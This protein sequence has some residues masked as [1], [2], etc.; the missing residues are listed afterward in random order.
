M[1][2][3][4]KLAMLMLWFSAIAFAEEGDNLAEVFERKIVPLE[5]L[6]PFGIE[7]SK[8]FIPAVKP[9]IG[10]VAT[11]KGG[12]YVLHKNKKNIYILFKGAPLFENDKIIT[13]ENSELIAQMLDG[14]KLLIVENTKMTLNSAATDH[15]EYIHLFFG[16][17]RVLA[18]KIFGGD[19]H[20]YKTATATVGIRGSD[21]MLAVFSDRQTLS[22][23]II[24]GQDT[25]VDF[26][27]AVGPA[28]R[29]QSFQASFAAAGQQAHEP[30]KISRTKSPS[31]LFPFEDRQDSSLT[32]MSEDQ[33]SDVTLS[34][35]KTENDNNFLPKSNPDNNLTMLFDKE[36]ADKLEETNSLQGRL[37]FLNAEQLNL[38][39]EINWDF[40][41]NIPLAVL[42]V[43]TDDSVT[44]NNLEVTSNVTRIKFNPLQNV[45][46]GFNYGNFASQY[47]TITP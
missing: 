43:A 45:Y 27:G 32:E 44:F 29:L 1:K 8:K 5:S 33:L 3:F 36:K 14:N 18:A 35:S 22:T 12:A 17:V 28:Q 30:L 4:I 21:F 7:I 25:S 23:A 13:A 31:V 15:S 11:L 20:K 2:N 34:F 10:K 16:K 38:F 40:L 9:M 41:I 42:D 6:L 19:V 39:L 46:T 26:S 37:Q 24:T 47:I